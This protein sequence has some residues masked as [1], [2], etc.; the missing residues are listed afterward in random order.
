[1]SLK[2]RSCQI[3]KY[4]INQKEPVSIKSLATEFEVSPRTISY[5]LDDIEYSIGQYNVELIK[6]PG[7]GI[8]LKGD[9]CLLKKLK[10]K[11]LDVRGYQRILSSEE[12]I[13]LILYRLFQ[14]EEPIITKELELILKV[15][16]ST[17]I[18]DLDEVE[19]WL[20]IHN[21]KLIRR[22]NYGL[23]VE[24]KELDIRHAM[25]EVFK[26]SVDERELG[27]FLSQIKKKDI[28]DKHLEAGFL[29]ELNKLITKVDLTSI[30]EIVS[31]VEEKLGF[32]LADEA[33]L[34]L[35]VYLALV[36]SRILEGKDICLSND[37]LTMIEK[38]SEYKIAEKSARIMGEVFKIKI[39]SS[40]I[41]VIT[42][43]LM[44]A[45]L[46]QNIDK[47]E[48]KST[49]END[50][51]PD[52]LILTKEMIKVAEDYLKVN[53]MGDQQLL[54]ALALHLKPTINRIN[55]DLSLK[56]PFLAEIK[57]K[58]KKLFIAA[59]RSAKILQSELC[60]DI[61]QDEVGYIAIHFGAA[62]EKKR[63]INFNYKFKV[64]LVCYSGMGTSN[65]LSSR[66]KQQFPEIEISKVLSVAHL[67]ENRC[68]LE[69]VDLVITTI[70]LNIESFPVLHVNPL[71]D[72]KDKLKIKE[73]IQK[74]L[75]D[76]RGEDNDYSIKEEYAF[77]LE[78]L[79]NVIKEDVIILKENNL[80]NSLKDFF[81]SK[82]IKV[83][84]G[85]AFNQSKKEY[86]DS[87]LN[88]LD[89]D[90]IKLVDKLSDWE[91]GIALI[92]ELLKKD[93]FIEETYVQR[94][95]E[96]IK[97]KG[98]YVVI[99]PHIALVH[100]RPEDGVIK[101]SIGL[102]IVKNGVKFNHRFDPVHLI[103]MLVPKDR[104]SHLLVLEDLLKL[105]DTDDLIKRILSAGDKND[106]I[107][108]IRCII[109]N[110]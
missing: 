19:D 42:L 54:I 35:L 55:Y 6:K 72:N 57:K 10:K 110:Y 98:P 64:A 94:S 108:I 36:V 34:D 58:Y 88:L 96:I 4:L 65:L 100:A 46:W 23:K 32:Q 31:F 1:M 7:V 41:A 69:K 103:F 8:S 90:L 68:D 45:K 84:D 11:L 89:H 104:L 93:R 92:G 105:I 60:K 37:K 29:S 39:T 101:K 15:S 70:P 40:E 13:Y 25:M 9:N 21:L 56:N 82:G 74:N 63:L 99:A 47:K 107:K 33:Y 109:E 106:V 102:L 81:K 12:R 62:L 79:I 87:L 66:L 52:L 73:I 50:L 97:Q 24:G 53:L 76:I 26:E 38:N 77:Q 17:I 14:A 51:D 44:G 71:L 22:T 61:S 43:H 20:N 85:L 91:E 18:K 59:E 83:L 48:Y 75:E 86:H 16:K 30:E 78:E 27:Q 5:D 80:K 49:S 2:S 28:K 67:E 95:I 3:L